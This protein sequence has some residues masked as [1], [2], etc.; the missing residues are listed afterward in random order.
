MLGCDAGGYW[1]ANS[2]ISTGTQA[3]YTVM[4]VNFSPENTSG[5]YTT[6]WAVHNANGVAVTQS[7]TVT[8]GNT[9]CIP[10]PNS[11]S[12]AAGSMWCQ[13]AVRVGPNDKAFTAALTLTQSGRTRTIS[14]TATIQAGT[15]ACNKC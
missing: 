3:T 2:C 8:Y 5:T 7:C 9:P 4:L 12:C 10:S 13:I 14:A 6:S 1:S 11:G 15:G